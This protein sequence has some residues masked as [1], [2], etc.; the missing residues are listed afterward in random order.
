MPH[1]RVVHDLSN[2]LWF[3]FYFSNRE[4]WS[5]FS[6]MRTSFSI[7]V[8]LN[9]E[10]TV[11]PPC[12]CST[13]F[14]FH[15]LIFFGVLFSTVSALLWFFFEFFPTFCFVVRQFSVILFPCWT[16]DL[17]SICDVLKCWIILAPVG[18]IWYVE[19]PQHACFLVISQNAF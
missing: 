19:F 14:L 7:H 1:R 6:S 18:A 16:S 13:S 9:F 8:F 15:V 10:G 2:R 3:S 17:F 12:F 5:L 11:L 4:G